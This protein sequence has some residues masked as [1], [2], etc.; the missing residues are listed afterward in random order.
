MIVCH[1]AWDVLGYCLCQLSRGER[2]C[3]HVVGGLQGCTRLYSDDH[4][5]NVRHTNIG[6][7]LLTHMGVQ[8]VCALAVS[9][10]VRKIRA[11][12]RHCFGTNVQY[13]NCCIHWKLTNSPTRFNQPQN[14]THSL[15]TMYRCSMQV[16]PVLAVLWA[17]S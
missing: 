5:G 9:L 1:K 16:L 17:T 4:N 13:T 11:Y 6:N 3:C 12:E 10:L 14:R 2:H 7:S 8:L 15:L